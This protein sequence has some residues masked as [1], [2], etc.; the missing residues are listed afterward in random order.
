MAK[1]NLQSDI[2]YLE[3]GV[4]AGNSFKWWA[5]HNGNPKSQFHGFD[6]FEGLPEDWGVF[7][8]GDMST[9]S[10]FP[11]IK[12][13]RVTF[14]KG[15]FQKTLPGFIQKA[16]WSQ[17]KVIHMDADLYSSTLYVLTMLAPYLKKDD[18]VMFDEYT[19]PRHE[20]LA[21]KNFV[22]SYYLEFELIAAANNY[23]FC[24][25]KMK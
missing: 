23:F 18:V 7:K 14:H 25:F 21:F 16:N 15:L 17:R 8:A 20:F 4:A 13:E 6:T 24:A 12:D 9:G 1:E 19:V 5:E 10:K 3:F 2:C 11:D 22:E